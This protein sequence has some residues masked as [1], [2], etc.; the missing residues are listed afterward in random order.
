MKSLNNYNNNLRS[1]LFFFSIFFFIAITLIG[2][3]EDNDESNNSST[4][5][6]TYDGV[7]SSIGVKTN[8]EGKA[9]IVTDSLLA[10]YLIHVVDQNGTPLPQITVDYYEHDN[11]SVIH[12]SDSEG[13]YMEGVIIGNPE[14][15]KTSKEKS[16]QPIYTN[17]IDILQKETPTQNGMDYQKIELV[18]T[19]TNISYGESNAITAYEASAFYITG[20]LV[21]NQWSEDKLNSALEKLQN[22]NCI[23]FLNRPTYR[24]TT[25]PPPGS[26]ITKT[27]WIFCFYTD[28]QGNSGWCVLS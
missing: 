8:S 17:N 10:K 15:M 20:P 23:E 5:K 14:D 21:K 24:D 3:G 19:I 22:Q 27:V 18:A 28:S 1:V 25:C 16:I 2:C 12:I 13:K 6:N 11:Q 7:S 4:N 9:I 26:T